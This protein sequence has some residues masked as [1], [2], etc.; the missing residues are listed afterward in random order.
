MTDNKNNILF[1]LAPKID[2]VLPPLSVP[3]LSAYL[4]VRGWNVDAYDLNI[5]CYGHRPEKYLNHWNVEF[6]EFWNDDK[7]VTDFFKDYAAEVQ[8]MFDFIKKE[9]PAYIGFSTWLTNFCSSVII[10]REIKKKWPAIKIIFGGVD[11]WQ[12]LHMGSLDSKDHAFIDAFVIGEGEA[13][14]HE[15]LCSF[16]NGDDISRCSGIALFRNKKLQV[17]SPHATAVLC[18]DLPMPDF[19]GFNLKKYKTQGKQLPLYL[20]RGC[21]NQCIFCE[22]RKFWRTYRTKSGEQLYKEIKQA[23]EQYPDFKSI[24]F[25]ESLINGNINGLR[26]LCLLLIEAGIEVNWEGNAIIRKEMDSDLLKLMAK[27]GC[28]LLVYGVETVSK[29]L[30]AYVGKVMAN[31]SD[32]EKIVRDTAEAGIRVTLDFMF[33]LPGETEEDAQENIDFVIRNKKYI[34]TIYPSWSFCY[35]TQLSD[36]YANPVRWGLKPITDVSFWESIDGSNTYPVRLERFE[37]FCAAMKKEGIAIQYPSDKLTDREKKLGYYYC[38]KK[39]YSKAAMY[40]L[41]ALQKEPWDTVLRGVAK[42]CCQKVNDEIDVD[43]TSKH[44]VDSSYKH[45]D[46]NWVNGVA[47]SWAAAFFVVNSSHARSKLTV[48]KRITFAGGT[49]RTIVSTKEDGGSLIIFLDGAPLDGTVV[50]YPQKFTVNPGG[51]KFFYTLKKKLGSWHYLG[52]FAGSIVS[53]L[54]RRRS[55]FR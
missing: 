42:T 12:K 41:Q 1:I 4:K 13:T 21:I 23:K 18:K 32:I 3:C 30:L 10:A 50:G 54:S 27:A 5:E 7:A 33:G 40:L 16:K 6:Q 43:S 8:K 44:N 45:T 49:A 11:I 24:Y 53:L 51:K 22:E 36:A 35:L 39:D 29:K 52:F 28:W 48:G 2:T 14:L 19:T 37:R 26:K 55:F 34:H 31:G 17:L 9:K 25:S 46:E 15:L 38:F 20:S 47:R